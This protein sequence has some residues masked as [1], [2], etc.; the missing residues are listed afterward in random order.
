MA[1]TAALAFACA[2]EAAAQ[3][4]ST[5]P[6]TEG[7]GPAVDVIVVSAERRVE[8]LQTAPLS[9]AVVSGKDI[10]DGD[11][12]DVSRLEEV[13][14]G[15][16][17]GRSG[18]AERPAIRGVYTE[19]VGINSD[20]RIGFYID[21]IYQSRPQQT[22]ATLVDLD[23]VEVQKGPQG[24]LFGRN[25]YGGNIA[26]ST[27]A[28]T[29]RV[30]GGVEVTA[31]NYGRARIEGFYNTPLADGLDGRIAAEYERHD[32]YLRSVVNS[33]ADLEDKGEYYVRGALKW[34]PPQLGSKLEVL[35]RA[36]YYNRDDHGY[37]NAN[38]KVIGV[39]VD[40]K[41]IVAPGGTVM[42]NGIPYTFANGFN[43]LSLGTGKLYPFTNAFR[44]NVPDVNGADVGLPV[45]GKYKT[46]YDF[47]AYEHLKQQQY[48]AHV[49]YDLN[50]WVKLRSI[51]SYAKFS[52][53]NAGDGD[54]S[55][56]PL[57]A[58]VQLTDAETYTQEFQLQSNNT[59]SPL[60]YTLG[61]FFLY[62]T[63][64]A[65]SDY[66]VL[67]TNYTTAG[68]S[69]LGLPALYSYGGSNACTQNYAVPAA[70]CFVSA[71]GLAGNGADQPT[72]E[73]ALTRSDAAYA[74]ASYKVTDKL[75]LT[76][77]VRY[78][79]DNKSY[80]NLAQTSDFVSTYVA[81]KNAA[82]T[83][84]GQ[85]APYTNATGYRAYFPNP[86]DTFANFACGGNTPAT[87][88]AFGTMAVAGTVPDYFVTR[89]G[90]RSFS[91]ATYRLAADYQLTPDNFLYAS[92]N[93]G[94][95]SGGF[96]TSPLPATTA[97][98]IFSTFN[99]EGVEAF[100]VGSKNEFLDRRF[101]VNVAAF[102]NNYT[103]LQQQGLQLISGRNIATIFN[104][105]SEHAPGVDFDFIAKPIPELT[106][107]W[108]VNYLHARTS[109]FPV[110]AYNSFI[111][112]YATGPGCAAGAANTASSYGL[113]SGPG[114][115][116]PNAFTNA[117]LFV[118]F[119]VNAAGAVTSYETVFPGGKS[120]VQNTPD[121]SMQF[122]ATYEVDFNQLGRVAFAFH[123]LYSGD[124]IISPL[125]PGLNQPAYLKSDAR[126]VWTAPNGRYSARL[127][128]NNLENVVTLSR[129]TTGSAQVAGTYDD[130]RTYG[131]RL[132]YNF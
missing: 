127:F 66:Y 110:P 46:L 53:T 105:P 117:N 42:F 19:A 129:A 111:C 80:K 34:V 106:L 4:G 119:N 102:Y 65:G 16:R 113:A 29:D 38:A 120:R 116:F 3:Q 24:T 128:V 57:Q 17:L 39:L 27:A 41:L 98:G 54:G 47:P 84:A 71:A 40:P 49:S 14:P 37:N 48:S 31:G 81:A 21:D 82:A 75:R 68:A 92:F 51:T 22:T 97:N 33:R 78:T 132:G 125:A 32:G 35:L 91:F 44:D 107:T 124:Y 130:P 69:A 36:S 89:C 109:P 131:V 26:L 93:T 55:P 104:G 62:D 18:A 76:A 85:P 20:P 114:G 64:R 118:P 6:A 60:E 7:A 126:V 8:P 77:G 99:S 86:S 2:G 12:N 121:I 23:H 30:G 15:L 5:K 94:R 123:T 63:N 100:E 72:A 9:V 108:S 1:S 50:P 83:L 61:A 13:A 52:T 115:Y 67:N 122:G 74:Q 10:K 73:A 103:H 95:H 43:G 96:G 90:A 59:D 11:I 88:A 87:F 56:I 25:S 112:F 28:P 79:V 45:P 101:Q 70:G 58:Y